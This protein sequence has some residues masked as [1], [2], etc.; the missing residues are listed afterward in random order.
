MKIEMTLKSKSYILDLNHVKLSL[1]IFFLLGCLLVGF[2]FV[3][4]TNTKKAVNLT[5]C[6]ILPVAMV[7][8]WFLGEQCISCLQYIL[9]PLQSQETSL[10]EVLS[11][12]LRQPWDR[13]LTCCSNSGQYWLC[14]SPFTYKCESCFHPNCHRHLQLEGRMEQPG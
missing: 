2:I 14:I 13:G 6:Q 7:L 5:F 10:W 3:K 12:V 1:R 4:N 11:P 9:Y 8:C